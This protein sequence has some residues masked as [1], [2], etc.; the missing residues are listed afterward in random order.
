MGEVDSQAASRSSWA[1]VCGSMSRMRRPVST[2]SAR[3]PS[4]PPST[5]ANWNRLFLCEV[6]LGILSGQGGASASV[7]LRNIGALTKVVLF[8]PKKITQLVEKV[9]AHPH[10]DTDG[11]YFARTELILGMLHKTKKRKTRAI[12]H[13]TEAQRLVAPAGRSTMAT[14]IEKA[15]AELAQA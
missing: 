11:H 13:L 2:A 5:S 4:F 15:L 7:L 3:L 12:A 1:A 9:R 6:Y 14:R 10:F 8:G